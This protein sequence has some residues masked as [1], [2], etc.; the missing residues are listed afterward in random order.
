MA[1]VEHRAANAGDTEPSAAA[2]GTLT[3]GPAVTPAAGVALPAAIAECYDVGVEVARGGM[4][5]VLEAVD[6][7]LQRH[8]AVK[9]MLN[10]DGALEEQVQ[11]FVCEARVT[12][13]LEHPGIVPVHQL[14]V[15]A[16]GRL[17][18]A[19][20]LVRGTTVSEI[21]KRLRAG[22]P[23]VVTKYPLGALLTVFLKVCDA[24]AFAHSRGVLH[25]DL[26][27]ENIMVGEYGEVLVM[28]WGL[29]K[30]VVSAEVAGQ[31]SEVSTADEGAARGAGS[32]G[33]AT[34]RPDPGL[35]ASDRPVMTM[36]GQ[37]LGTPAYMAP[38]QAR[39]E[40]SAL[41]ARTDIYSLGA[42]LY[43]LLVLQ[44]PVAGRTLWEV[45]DNVVKGRVT[46]P[47]THNRTTFR[48][49][50]SHAAAPPAVSTGP[51]GP[52]A[53]FAHCPGGRVPAALSRVTM[54]AMAL[55][56]AERY[57]TVPDLQAD[58]E[59][60]RNGFATAAEEAGLW[61]QLQ[62]LLL[63]HKTFVTASVLVFL[64]VT[65][66]LAVSVTQWHK[67]VRAE[68]AEAEQRQRAESARA[69]AET[70]EKAAVAARTEAE[71]RRD[72]AE[73]ESYRALI[74]ATQGYLDKG[75]AAQAR[76]A[77]TSCPKRFRH[78]EWGFLS[79][80]CRRIEE[81]T[82]K[83]GQNS[84]RVAVSVDGRYAAWP[85]ADGVVVEKVDGGERRVIA[86]TTPER[87]RRTVCLTADG[88][89]LVVLTGGFNAMAGVLEL[90]RVGTGERV[91]QTELP[92][93]GSGVLAVASGAPYAVAG[94]GSDNPASS[95][96][97]RLFDLRTGT[98][99]GA[100]GQPDDQALAADWTPDGKGVWWLTK[101]D[102]RLYD[103]QTR[104]EVRRIAVAGDSVLDLAVAPDGRRLACGGND[105][106]VRV[107]DTTSGALIDTL[108]QTGPV[109]AVLFTDGGRY[110]LGG[111]TEG[112]LCAWDTDTGGLVGM[113]RGSPIR[114]LGGS[115]SSETVYI[116]YTS[117]ILRRTTLGEITGATL[118]QRLAE[119]FGIPTEAGS[120]AFS[121]GGESLL[122]STHDTVGLLT[123]DALSARR[124]VK[125]ATRGMPWHIDW[126]GQETDLV[127]LSS[128]NGD[129]GVWDLREGRWV[130]E[131]KGDRH[132]HAGPVVCWLEPGKALVAGGQIG[133]EVTVYDIGTG[134]PIRRFDGGVK[135]ILA[136]ALSP[137]RRILYV[138]G[139]G[140]QAF[141][142]TTWQSVPLPFGPRPTYV[143]GMAFSPNGEWLAL[144]G[145]VGSVAGTHLWRTDRPAAPHACAREVRDF[146]LAFTADGK[147]LAVSSQQG[148]VT[149]IDP[150]R[151]TILMT[152]AGHGAGTI[153]GL[154]F[155]P[156]SRRL[157]ST[158]GSFRPLLNREADPWTE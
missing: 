145:A 61:R 14:G 153:N 132:G 26:K 51:D 130:R 4:G 7:S 52:A 131:Y 19:M 91:W 49:R 6:H 99:L 86:V 138:G 43:T 157:V 81:S 151:G 88:E 37:I 45:L 50:R 22:E 66:G 31:Q 78:W 120:V 30:R 117:L 76:T 134:A 103:V 121:R 79:R 5:A 89:G 2:P 110:L 112:M 118:T 12:G 16:E 8:V 124:V 107:W 123:P 17:F 133:T 77:L 48:T 122:C 60:W 36:E 102:L 68:K 69:Q 62:L 58:I 98:V 59:A 47:A 73:Y 104:T 38:E 32:G 75:E 139:V 111:S 114:A 129:V 15:D 46:P 94:G 70:S 150:E 28:D 56:P 54:K 87:A 44:P 142:T 148:I 92:V 119:F 141:D 90:Y 127:A 23:D 42:I 64:A 74:G 126:E 53:S 152:L 33:H 100:L 3:Y 80:Q 10:Q 93:A 55:A 109:R 63:R 113:M 146:H 35:P 154:A 71:V 97:F 116:V 57:Q 105:A 72:Q 29:A 20:K 82:A 67:A 155:A 136:M 149:L 147:R 39:G 137:D 125:H 108:W 21:T 156:D 135:L 144:C 41:D 24:V 101:T 65:V 96:P 128:L 143:T 1:R 85:Q 18:Y 95:V 106:S 13:Q 27:P 83:S 25:R 84:P 140:L 115:P 34:P 158:A 9:V 11:R 40:I